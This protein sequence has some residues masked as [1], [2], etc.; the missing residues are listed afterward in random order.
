MYGSEYYL[1]PINSGRENKSTV[2]ESLIRTDMDRKT[3]SKR[4]E[5]FKTNTKSFFLREA[6]FKVLK[7]SLPQGIDESYLN[8]GKALIDN[9]IAEEKVDILLNRFDT[10]TLFLS[11]M[12][13]IVRSSY[14]TVIE[15][16]DIANPDDYLIKQ[17]DVTK[18]YDKLDGLDV[19]D[20]CSAIA[21]K[22]ADAEAEFVE[23]NVKDRENIEKL[24]QET[25]DKI[26]NYRNKDA[27][28][29]EAVRESYQREYKAKVNA[30]NRNRSRGLLECMVL[31]ASNSVMADEKLREVYTES[32]KVNTNRIIDTCEVMYTFLEMVNTAKIRVVDDKYVKE[33]VES[34]N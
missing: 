9:F 28:V 27:E 22:V 15:N 25:K 11:E 6:M 18:F 7:G 16:T 17:S 31:K 2:V 1:P 23:A 4:L 30:I 8:T 32:G 19:D 34:I 26:D 14:E 33:V 20:M 21:T 5:D 24:A 13:E 10:T 3:A 12:S 29:T